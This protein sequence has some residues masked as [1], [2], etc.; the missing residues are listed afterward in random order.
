MAEKSQE[1]IIRELLAQPKTVAVVGL[2]GDTSRTSYR[3]CRYLQDQGYKIIPVNPAENQVLGNKAYQTLA[4]IEEPVDIV[5]I[6]RANEY[7]GPFVEEAIAMHPDA[8]WLPVGVTCRDGEQH[9]KTEGV[10]FV[11][12][13]CMMAEH[14][15]LNAF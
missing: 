14:A 15:R 5:Y 9:C 3:V 1:Q 2:S 7:V 8:V 12:N 11:S 13:R 6:F 10:R 4:D